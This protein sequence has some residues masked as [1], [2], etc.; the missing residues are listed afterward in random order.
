MNATITEALPTDIPD[1]EAFMA[2]IF[3]PRGGLPE[4]LE[5]WIAGDAYSLLIARDR[6][7]LV[8][9]CTWHFKNE[10]DLTKYE[11]F[12]EKAIAFLK[13]RPTVW[14]VNLAVAPEHRRSG[15]GMRLSRAQLPWLRQTESEIVV[16]SSWVNGTNDSSR[17]MYEKAGFKLLGESRD[18]L[19][20]QQANGAICAACNSSSCN[21]NS[22]FY[23]IETKTLLTIERAEGRRSGEADPSS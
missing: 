18:F 6:E 13:D 15:L 3:G 22:L 2:T 1:I 5:K 23:G 19:R 8:G 4:L 21:C 11:C 20:T 9:I 16:G 14:T 7:K 17:Q 10:N 12:G